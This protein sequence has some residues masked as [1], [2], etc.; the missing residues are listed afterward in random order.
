VRKDGNFIRDLARRQVNA[1]AD[2]LDINC[3]PLSKDPVKDMVW[4]VE[5]IQA[6]VSAVLCLDS[7]KRAVIEAG[8]DVCRG[9][10]IINSSSA[11]ED[12][13][14]GYLELAKTRNASLIALT[15]DRNGVP[16][17]KE[18]RLELAAQILDSASRAD[19]PLTE[20]YLDPVLM[21]INVAQ[22]QL[23][24][25]LQVIND[26]RLLSAPAVQTVLGL[27]NISQGAK[28]RHIINRTFLVMAQALGLSAAILDPLDKE[29]M[30]ALV[31][32]ELILNK[33]IYCDSYIDAY[34]KSKR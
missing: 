16:Q 3:G 17:N 20:L 2:A 32:G 8:L 18:K 10:A 14:A 6:E 4:L 1:G 11:D 9:K 12:K 5:T 13:L 7:T 15:M 22:Q 19:F 28:S 31:T 26:F 30:Q 33:T 21:P 29:L 23:Y 27:S 24:D 25:I 34:L